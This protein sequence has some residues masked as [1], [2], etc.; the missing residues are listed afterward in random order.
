MGAE[1]ISR[2]EGAPTEHWV[3]AGRHFIRCAGR[4]IE[5]L[6]N[7]ARILKQWM[8]DRIELATAVTR[9]VED[10]F[11]AASLILE[12]GP[13]L[14]YSP[15]AVAGLATVAVRLGCKYPWLGG[16]AR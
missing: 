3:D 4:T 13:S 2:R 9:A 16:F 12:S 8:T 11:A 14:A 10:D 15:G 5:A 6:G 1:A 7:G